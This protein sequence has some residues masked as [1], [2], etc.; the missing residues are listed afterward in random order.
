M[1]IIGYIRVSTEEQG[2]SGLSLAA[3]AAKIRQYCELHEHTLLQVV[4][5]VGSAKNLTD[6]PAILAVVARCRAK[7][8][9]GLIVA[10]LDR[11]TRSIRDLQELLQQA[12][13]RFALIFVQDSL[14]TSTATGRLMM[15]FMI[16]VSQWEREVIGERTAAALC[17]LRRAGKRNSAIAPYGYRFVPGDYLTKKKTPG[18]VL[19]EDDREMHNL[20]LMLNMVAN[21]RNYHDI[22]NCLDGPN[23]A[24]KPWTAAAVRK[25]LKKL[26]LIK[27]EL[28]MSRHNV[29]FARHEGTIYEP[30]HQEETKDEKERRLCT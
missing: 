24:G 23:R 22:A 21:N 6:R 17:E 27:E 16:S 26:M 3:Q 15:N 8:A 10:K 4:E 11:L 12:N 18:M 29:R 14:D 20:H 7:K 2:N 9:D 30:P 19:V 25:I 5:E 28:S 13:E 1:N